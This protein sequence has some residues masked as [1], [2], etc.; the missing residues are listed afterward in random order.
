MEELH[1]QVLAQFMHS[2]SPD[3][4]TRTMAATMLVLTLWQAVGRAMTP[5]PPSM[6]LV[7]ATNAGTDPLDAFAEYHAAGAGTKKPRE[8]GCG[9]FLGRKPE[10]ARETM[11]E[12]LT[13]HQELGSETIHN[14]RLFRQSE[15]LFDD[16]KLTGYGGGPA[17]CYSRVW[18]DQ[19][20]WLTDGTGDI[21]LR[22]DQPEDHQAFRRDL[23]ECRDK[24]LTPCGL[25]LSL[26]KVRKSLVIS[27]SLN[28]EQW[29]DALVTHV[30]ELGLPF[31]YLPH[32]GKDPLTVPDFISMKAL[33]VSISSLRGN[34]PQP[35]IAAMRIATNDWFLH[36]EKLLRQ[37]LRGMTG[38]YE[39]SVQ[40]TVH[41]LGEVCVRIARFAAAPG[42]PVNE[43]LAMY[44]DLHS[45]AFRG[46][47]IGIHSLAYH[48][49][50]V[51]LGCRRSHAVRV[52][53]HIREKGPLTRRDLQRKFPKITLPERD[54][55]LERLASEGL[56][57][58]DG[59]KVKAVTLE[60]FVRALHAR[61]EFHEPQ[62]F[63]PVL[64]G[65]AS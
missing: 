32:V 38:T 13:T 34:R 6:L 57:E 50:G 44:M 8:E 65:L 24:L 11:A 27:G 47:V 63:S 18:D 28:P 15:E 30:M 54:R 25:D 40:Q 55:L 14:D 35:V 2:C 37:R 64:L 21:I 39:F 46:I 52:L 36:Y 31:F 48:C 20:G 23:F 7:N 59:S 41:E 29:D 61:P 58:L 62:Y 53:R 1:P 51:D 49:L 45:M 5:R 16:A 33:T 3:P 12:A 42:T 17:G 60:D 56:V 9:R 26:N 10:D 4:S 22:L 43:V 19:F